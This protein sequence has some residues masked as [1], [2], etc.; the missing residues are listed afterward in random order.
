MPPWPMAMPSSTAMVLNSLETPP[1]SRIADATRSPMSLRCTWPGTNCVY[2]L[3]IA[4]IG[5]PKSSAPMPV[6]RQRARAPA[7]LRPWVDV[8]ERRG[9][10]IPGQLLRRGAATDPP[11]AGSHYASSG[12]SGRGVRLVV[13]RPTYVATRDL[14]D[15]HAIRT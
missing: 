4:M 14:R 9:R 6:A 7:M 3:A 2:E 12:R 8:R 11:A 5:L 15:V 1:A 10:L 13:V